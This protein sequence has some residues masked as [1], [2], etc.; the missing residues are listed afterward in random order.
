MWIQF[1]GHN[2]IIFQA[3]EVLESLQYLQIA[4]GSIWLSKLNNVFSMHS[5]IW[6][7]CYLSM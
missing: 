2:K 4:E 5:D 1:Y 7:L 6:P 3:Y